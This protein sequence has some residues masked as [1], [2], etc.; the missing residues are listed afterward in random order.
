[1]VEN[2]PHYSTI[3]IRKSRVLVALHPRGANIHRVILPPSSKVRDGLIILSIISLIWL[4]N[5]DPKSFV[6]RA[7]ANQKMP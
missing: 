3:C 4:R 1:M 7:L 6:A 5:V 2:L